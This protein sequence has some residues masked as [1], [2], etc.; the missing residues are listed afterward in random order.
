MT[1]EERIRYLKGLLKCELCEEEST[2]ICKSCDNR[3]IGSS[4]KCYDALKEVIKS[5]EQEQEPISETDIILTREEYGELVSSEYDNGYAKG[6]REALEQEPC[7]DAVSRQ[8][9]DRLV[10]RYLKKGTDENIAFYEHFLDLPS[11]TP[12]EPILNKIRAEIQNINLLSI[13]SRGDIKRMALDIIDK[14]KDKA[15]SEEK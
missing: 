15:E 6:Y 7:E 14:Y 9:V 2:K 8:A 5:L 3:R 10:W 1:K 11:V 4:A 13:I 12:Q